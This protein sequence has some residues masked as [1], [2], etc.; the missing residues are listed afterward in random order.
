MW[1]KPTP[2]AVISAVPT[3]SLGEQKNAEVANGTDEACELR[4]QIEAS[5]GSTAA[6]HNVIET[7]KYHQNVLLFPISKS[8]DNFDSVITGNSSNR[9]FSSDEADHRRTAKFLIQKQ[10]FS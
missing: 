6:K 4:L 1:I 7:Q 5:S 9:G 3:R 8:N 2:Q 10:H